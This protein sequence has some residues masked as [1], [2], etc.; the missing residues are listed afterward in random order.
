MADDPFSVVLGR[1]DDDTVSAGPFSPVLALGPQRSRKTTSMVVPSLL[2]WPGPAL[3]TSVRGDVIE[4][5]IEARRTMGNVQIIDPGDVMT[6]WSD[7]VGWSPLDFVNTPDDAAGVARVLVESVNLRGGMN[8]NYWYEAATIQLAPYLFAAAKNGRAMADVVHWVHTTD[9]NEVAELLTSSGHREVLEAAQSR[10]GGADRERTT[11][12]SIMGAC[13]ATWQ[14]RRL[15]NLSSAEDRFRFDKFL[16]GDP[17]TLYVCAPLDS[18]REYRSFIVSFLNLFFRQ[19]YY[20]NRGFATSPLDMHGPVKA[21]EE[22][23]GVVEPLLVVLDD[24]GNI[25][26]VP[27]LNGLVSTA[28]GAAVQFVTVFTDVSQMQFLYGEDTARSLVN[29]HSALMIM[30]GSHDAA[31]ADLVNQM[32]K[33]DAIRGLPPG[34]TASERVRRLPWGTALC[35]ASNRPPVVV[36]LR[37]S[38][39]DRDLLVLRGA[40]IVDH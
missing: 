27:H 20:A 1:V 33:D 22:S 11:V 24:A 9:Q 7:R 30:P 16:N 39:T 13:L 25:A 31:T 34:K 4:Q 21:L 23:E 2:E 17:N 40:E 10:W 3:V 8:E 35:V 6:D 38:L 14:R 28:A 15:Q 12:F 5:T 37:S 19:A 36:E 26:P 18:Q 32:L 29:N